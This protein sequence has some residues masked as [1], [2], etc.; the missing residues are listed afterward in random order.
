MRLGAWIAV[1]LVFFSVLGSQS[2]GAL[3]GVVAM[4]S[5]LIWRTPYKGPA[6]FAT[7]LLIMVGIW[8]VPESWV[9][10]MQTIRE[11][12]TD[13]SAMAR[14]QAWTF[15]VRLALD[16]PLTGGGFHVS[17]IHP[18]FLS[19]VP[20]A[21]KGRSFHSIWFEMLGAHGFV[22]LA[23][24]IVMLTLSWLNCNTI[25][26]KTKDLANLRWAFDLASMIQVSLIGFMA[27]GTFLNLAFFDLLYT[28]IAIVIGMR[29]VV[30]RELS[31]QTS[32]EAYGA[33]RRR[34]AGPGPRLAE[35]A[36][37]RAQKPVES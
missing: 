20:D 33:R 12:E 21:P 29:T 2:R 34:R 28:L 27:A 30:E 3:V 11:Y 18:L 35:T 24:F 14:I 15:A 25:R 26:R 5:F 19:Y 8:F 1:G 4:G 22:G 23:I 37:T 10:R 6:I 36:T 9:E 7:F 32:I 16:N 31:G 13:S 17:S